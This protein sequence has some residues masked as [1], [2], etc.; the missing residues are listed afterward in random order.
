VNFGGLY[1]KR[2]LGEVFDLAMNSTLTRTIN[3]SL[4]TLVVLLVIFF[5]GGEVIRGF[6][7]ALIVGISV[8]T[9]SSIFIASPITYNYMKKKYKNVEN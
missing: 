8:G 5:F 9:Y 6:V 2:N 7:F 1:P 3:T 4:T